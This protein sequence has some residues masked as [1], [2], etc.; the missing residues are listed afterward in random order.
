MTVHR[1]LLATAAAIVAV[2]ATAA[3]AQ[4]APQPGPHYE[5]AVPQQGGGVVYQSDPVVQPL[6]H[7]MPHPMERGSA[8]S[9][10]GHTVY[11]SE[12]VVDR[13]PPP[14]PYPEAYP[15]AYPAPYPG[16][17]PGGYDRLPPQFDR[18]AWLDDCHDRIRGVS[19]K[20]RGR[21]IGGLLGAI[22]GGV[23]GNRIADH[24]RLAGTVIGA[25]VGGV[26][27]LAI[28]SAIGAAG[29]RR[30]AD[31]CAWSLDHYSGGYPGG[32]DFAQGPAYPGYGYPGYA[33]PAGYGYPGYGYGAWGYTM[34]P[35]LVA[36]PQ[37]QVVR[38][39]ITEEYVRVPVRTRTVV[40]TRVIQ[41]AAP[42]PDK[43]IKYIKGN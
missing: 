26:A 29:D 8:P 10:H 6:P 27:G 16:A 19:G 4:G 41:Q 20:E 22:A 42:R 34:M 21:V 33:Y 38:E 32:P 11:R 36:V 30:H 5:Y 13:G 31:E 18:E 39:T 14:P 25:G 3:L 9:E 23:A 40:R 15:G 17:Y 24:N 1:R 2:P 43:R 28:G 12:T 7:P 37:R 35:V